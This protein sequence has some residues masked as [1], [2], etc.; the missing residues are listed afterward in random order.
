MTKILS[1]I[2]GF[3]FF[4]SI[5][6]AQLTEFSQGDILSAGAM[7]QNF[8]YLEDRFGGLNEKTVD[9]GTSGTGS[10]INAAIKD[11]YNSIIVKGICKENISI[12]AN[13]GNRNYLKLKGFN[14]D[15]N[16]DKIV[17]NSSNSTAVI[18]IEGSMVLKI[19]NLTLS[20][21]DRGIRVDGTSSIFADNITVESY[22]S[23][24]IQIEGPSYL[25]LGSV[26]ID[27][28]KQSAN[29]DVGVKLGAG[30]YG[31]FH[32]TTT[33][34]GNSSNSGGIAA[35]GGIIWMT[36]TVNLD[37]NKQSLVIE[38]GGKMGLWNSTTT[39]S[40][41]T[42]YG[43]K[44]YFGQLWNYGTMTISDSSDGNW[45]VLIDRSGAYLSNL[46]VTGGSG[47]DP[48]IGVYDSIFTLDDATIKNHQGDL[49]NS[50]RSSLKFSGT[51]SV[52]NEN[53]S[54]KCL[55]YF[56]DVDFEFRG[57]TTI[58]GTNNSS[59]SALGMKRSR[60]VIRNISISSPVAALYME[61]S[62]VFIRGGSFSSSG[63]EAI[64]PRNGSRLSIKSYDN[65]VSITSSADEALEIKSS[66]VQLEKGSNDLTIS[67]TASDKADISSEEISTL[68]IEDH[69]FSS[70]EIEA[71][72]SLILNDDATIT[73][74][75]CSSTSNIEKDGTVTNSTGCA[76]AQ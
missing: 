13:D 7:N 49:I 3:I 8:K 42:D 68:V 12:L 9:C 45:G 65:N 57:T 59:C 33:V 31:Y 32:G 28:T 40:N 44:A 75:S 63:K 36:G 25:E 14:N 2:I 52:L 10:G 43:I 71:G 35:S 54:S 64:S 29:D 37:S 76:Q 19:D 66:F 24:G 4:G 51:N 70:V 11:G 20:G 41:S 62:D 30:S 53:S 21:G 17:D 23:Y 1:T 58:N 47:S 48:L 15:Q 67:S 18:K 5:A 56:E 26:K 61:S 39:I 72:S 38:S 50:T 16:S 73:T 74:L 6:S 27:G 46:T 55:I 34:N 69:T 60:G 22:T